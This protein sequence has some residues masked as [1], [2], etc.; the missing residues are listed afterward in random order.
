M[1]NKDEIEK[2][3]AEVPFWWHSI[4]LPH[5]VVT[6]GKVKDSDIL[7]KRLQ[8]P[9]DLSGKRVLDIGAW[10]GYYSFECEKRG[11]QVLAIDNYN[12]MEVEEERQF[13]SIANRG[14]LVA[15]EILESRVDY[16]NLDVCDIEVDVTGSFDIVLFL[17]V[18]YHLR[19]P[20][21]ALEK[22]AKVTK[23]FAIV[24]SEIIR[25]ITRQ[26]SVLYAR[27]DEYNRDPTNWFIPTVAAMKGMLR[28][29]GFERVEVLYETPLNPLRLIK[30]L[31]R[32]RTYS[33]GR[34]VLKAFK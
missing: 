29:S 7:M 30:S 8:L 22:I 32:G 20:L 15:R 10:D 1:M 5:G 18:L 13:A 25:T 9:S 24:E 31:A 28:D 19:S 33:P 16:M 6:P 34:A 2:R 17:G 14:F 11:A 3:I 27:G 23:E 4:N 21:S 12:R 26:P